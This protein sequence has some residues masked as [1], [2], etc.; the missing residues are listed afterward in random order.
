MANIKGIKKAAAAT[1]CLT[2]YYGNLCVQMI[3]N[4]AT[5]E[6]SAHEH[7][8]HNSW[9]DLSNSPDCINIGNF[10]EPA[11][12]RGIAERVETAVAQHDALAAMA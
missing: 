5:G 3:Y 8:G 10:C 9:I 11:T 7:I 4:K 12:M 2:G 6:L 1:K